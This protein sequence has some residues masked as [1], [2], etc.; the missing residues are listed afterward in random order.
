MSEAKSGTGLTITPHSASRHAGYSLFATRYLAIR[1]SLRV[2]QH[3][4]SAACPGIP[5]PS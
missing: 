3:S 4:F 1:R 2:S 5:T